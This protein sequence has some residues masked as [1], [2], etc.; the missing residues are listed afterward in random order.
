MGPARF[1]RLERSRALRGHVHQQVPTRYAVGYD[2]ISI[3]GLRLE[4]VSDFAKPL[5]DRGDVLL[6]ASHGGVR[7]SQ[8]VG[9]ILV[10]ADSCAERAQLSPDL[11]MLASQGPLVIRQRAIA[12]QQLDLLFGGVWQKNQQRI[13]RSAIRW[14]PALA[15]IPLHAVDLN[16]RLA[17]LGIALGTNV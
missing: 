6:H 14:R 15:L 9:S 3:A 16:Q 10:S 7:H 13:S 8:S 1:R 11:P 17:Y 12:P 2:V 5:D 4:L